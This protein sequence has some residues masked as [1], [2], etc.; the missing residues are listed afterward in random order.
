[1]C[2]VAA[3]SESSR[4]RSIFAHSRRGRAV[5]SR[6]RAVGLRAAPLWQIART[7][8]ILRMAVHL[9]ATTA[10]QE[11]PSVFFTWRI[12]GVSAAFFTGRATG[13]G[14]VK[15][16][17]FSAYGLDFL[18]HVYPNGDTVASV[19][20]VSVFVHLVSPE[21]HLFKPATV[22]L[23]LGLQSVSMVEKTFSSTKSSP[24]ESSPSWG[25]PKTATHAEV[26]AAPDSYFPGGVLTLTVELQ[27]PKLPEAEM[28]RATEGKQ[29]S[30]PIPPSN[31]SSDLALLLSSCEGADLTL[32]C[33]R[34]RIKAHS[35]ILCARS[36]VFRAQLRG[37][38]ACRLDA[39]PVP[40]EIDAPTLRRTLSFIYTDECEPASAEEA[41]HLL[42]AADHYGLVRLRAICESKLVD[43]LSIENGAFTLTLAEQHS[44][45]ALKNAALLF[46]ARNA[47]A[48]MGTA[49]WAH[50]KQAAPALVDA[51]MHTLATGAPPPPPQPWPGAYPIREDD[52]RRV[53]QRT[54]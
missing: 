35:G 25:W 4:W 26:I 22:K 44:A 29:N 52:E 43:S 45:S 19:G 50:L 34:E 42:N 46:V 32:R 2:G 20:H 12:T 16:P 53:R 40:D 9:A 38:L 10:L 6:V 39:V 51:A 14:V 37:E 27:P 17:I 54:A 49:G 21:V 48:V 31:I 8:Q 36:P 3:A 47:V 11:A 30:V 5:S 23:T 15:S 13:T 7:R 18:L 1:M 33:G 24:A 28:N 41:Q